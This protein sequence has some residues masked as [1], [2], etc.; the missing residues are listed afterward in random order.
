M[1]HGTVNLSKP[2]GAGSD[3]VVARVLV[4]DD[5]AIIREPIAA[6]LEGRG[7]ATDQ[8]V[9][10]AAALAALDRRPA[11]LVLLDMEMPGMGGLEFLRALRARPGHADTRVVLLSAVRDRE[12]VAEVARLGVHG[13]LLKTS[14]STDALLRAVS[15][16]LQPGRPRAGARAAD[17]PAPAAGATAAAAAPATVTSTAP[18]VPLAPQAKGATTAAAVPR[19]LTRGQCSARAEA[20]VQAKALSGVVSEVLSMAGSPRCDMADLATLVSRDPMLSARVLQVANSAAYA[21]AR[22]L[23]TTIPEAVRKVGLA[24][25]RNAAAAV[26]VVGAVTV[27]PFVPWPDGFSPVRCWQ[28]SFAVARLCETLVAAEEPGLSGVAYL[29][30]LCHDVGEICFRTQFEAEYRQ[31]LGVHAGGA[32]GGRPVEQLERDM[33][34]LTRGELVI[35]LLATLGLPDTIARPI[36]EFHGGKAAPAGGGGALLCRVLRL[37]NAYAHGLLLAPDDGAKVA[38]LQAADCR[39]GPAGAPPPRPA[40]LE[41][42]GEILTLT[43]ILAR[44]GPGEEA[45]SELARYEPGAARVLL[46]RDPA[47]SPFDPL[48]AALASMASAVVESDACPVD[49]ASWQACDT[50]VVASRGGSPGTLGADDIARAVAA[51]PKGGPPV[52]WLTPRAQTVPPAGDVRVR[53]IGIALGE[54]HEFAQSVTA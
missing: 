30:G 37:A 45:S 16:A 38:P 18:A 35:R 43:G 41:F 14:F 4:V 28:H 19:L 21:S 29:V 12:T 15:E 42:R 33:L 25:V 26:G 50:L 44:P 27:A 53:P 46:V 32:G 31:L 49:A 3:G 13:Y 20:A 5:Q 40:A 51:H 10:G 39:F 1:T 24:A 6:W 9:D 17:R 11:D 23:V 36:E 34:G 47:Y 52:L 54:L 2:R 7:Y 22:G 8:A 48:A